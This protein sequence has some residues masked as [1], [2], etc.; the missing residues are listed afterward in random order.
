MDYKCKKKNKFNLSKNKKYIVYD[1][2]N[3]FKCDFHTVMRLHKLIQLL[4]QVVTQSE[5]NSSR[6]RHES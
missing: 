5:E 3:I 4:E 1:I 6:S 2:K